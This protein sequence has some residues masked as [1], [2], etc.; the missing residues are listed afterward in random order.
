[1]GRHVTQSE[2]AKIVGVT[3]GRVSQ[4]VSRG[5]LPRE[6]DGLLDVDKATAAYAAM[7]SRVQGGEVRGG[8]RTI[9]TPSESSPPTTASPAYSSPGPGRAPNEAIVEAE[10]RKRRADADIQEA[11]A[12]ALRGAL[13]DKT[14][15][16]RLIESASTALRVALKTRDARLSSQLVGLTA[17]EIRERL[18]ADSDAMLTEFLELLGA[19]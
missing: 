12:R 4:L 7:Q 13:V 14:K 8:A 16:A 10:V 2:F 15:V 17:T 19:A 5:R 18:A 1:M 6:P 9:V 11:K 3:K